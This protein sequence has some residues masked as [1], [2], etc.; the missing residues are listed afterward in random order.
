MKKYQLDLAFAI[1]T[2][3][4]FLF[5]PVMCSLSS[6]TAAAV[7]LNTTSSSGP[8]DPGSTINTFGT[9]QI[10]RFNNSGGND[11]AKTSWFHDQF[12]MFAR[13]SMNPTAAAQGGGFA[14][15]SFYESL[16]FP[17]RPGNP[18]GATGNLRLTYHL[19]GT[20]NIDIGKC[21][22]RRET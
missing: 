4:T 19:E 10:G 3:L 21:S 6:P 12:G 2:A 22:T 1:S 16:Q 9:T 5:C 17:P 11:S 18:Q 8:S 14:Y 13:G 7:Y 15:G 20:I